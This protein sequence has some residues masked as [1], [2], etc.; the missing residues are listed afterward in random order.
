MSVECEKADVPYA[1]GKAWSIGYRGILYHD[2]GIIEESHLPQ[3]IGGHEAA[4]PGGRY[5]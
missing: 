1:G 4:L 3:V 2:V 5:R